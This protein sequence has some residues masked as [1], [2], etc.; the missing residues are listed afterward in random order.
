MR[1]TSKKQLEKLSNEELTSEERLMLVKIKLESLRRG[2]EILI[3]SKS[4]NARLLGKATL[5]VVEDID[6]VFTK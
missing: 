6:K 4:T 1:K 3:N 2:A 5:A